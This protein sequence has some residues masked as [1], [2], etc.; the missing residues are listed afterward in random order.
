LVEI[1]VHEKFHYRNCV[2]PIRLRGNFE[3]L[4]ETCDNSKT[5]ATLTLTTSDEDNDRLQGMT[6]SL[7]EQFTP[8]IARIPRCDISEDSRGLVGRG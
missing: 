2:I 3:K 1:D 4:S 5:S 7:A 8:P 6:S